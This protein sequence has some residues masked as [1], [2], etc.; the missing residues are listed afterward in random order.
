VEIATM[1]T[2]IATD[3]HDDIGANLTKIAILSEVTRQQLEGNGEAGDRLST[4]ARISRE[5]VASMSDVVWAI[6]P[7]RDTLRDTIRRMRQHAE[8]VFAGRGV[9]LDFHAPE[10]DERVR[11]PLDVR[12]DLVLIF[13]EAL[14]NAVRHSECRKLRID[15]DVDQSGLHLRV[16]DDGVGFDTSTDSAGNGLTSMRRRAE[17]MGA[18]L[19]VVSAPGHGTAVLLS[20]PGSY[21]GRL[22]YPA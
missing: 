2:G 5:S 12:R 7:K 15:V 10:G 1:R 17:K 9:P 11:I 19:Q 16:A 14:N 4:I 22:R 21:A 20:V 6:N 8:E 13:K 3:L 18:T